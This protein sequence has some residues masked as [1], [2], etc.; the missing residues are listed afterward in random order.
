MWNVDINHCRVTFEE[1]VFE[2]QSD[3]F[4]PS[5]KKAVYTFGSNFLSPRAIMGDVVFAPS[6]IGSFCAPAEAC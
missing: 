5:K 3:S 2:A 1:G 6:Q 4:F